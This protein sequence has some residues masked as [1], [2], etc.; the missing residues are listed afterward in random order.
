MSF[1]NPHGFLYRL[2][3]EPLLLEEQQPFAMLELFV[4]PELEKGFAQS[5]ISGGSAFVRFNE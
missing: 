5:P 2:I 4:R 1:A 3:L